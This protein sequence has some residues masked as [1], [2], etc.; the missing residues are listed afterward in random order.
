MSKDVA[1]G[2]GLALAVYLGLKGINVLPVIFLA[3]VVYLLSQAVGLKGLHRRYMPVGGGPGISTVTF[4][5]I[6]GQGTAKKELLEALEFIT[7]REVLKKLGIRPLKGLLLTGPPGTGKTMLAKAAANYTNSVFLAAAGSEFIE[8]YAGVGA[9]RVRQLFTQAREA[10]RRE[11]KKSAV[12]F[13]DEIEV[14]GGQRGKHSSHLEYDQTLNQLLVEMDGISMDDEVNVL[15]V[16]ATNRMDLLDSAL[17]RP[18]RFD[19]LVKVELPD[20]EGRL[21]ILQLHTRNKPL[22][23]DVD[24]EQIARETFGFSGAHLE[25]LTNEAA[26]LAMR[27]EREQIEQRHLLEAIDKVIMGEKLERRPTREEMQRIALHEAAHALVGEINRPGSISSITVTSRGNALGYV[28]QGPRDDRY[29]YTQEYLEA[30]I[31]VLLAGAVAEEEILG[32]R[33]TGAASDFDRAVHHVREIIHSGM[34]YLGVVGRDMLPRGALHRATTKI[35]REQEE[36]VR[37]VVRANRHFLSIV[38]EML[39]ERESLPGDEFRRLRHGITQ[40]GLPA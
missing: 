6:G 28:R 24:L 3:A 22:G 9:Q 13:I 14:L 35:L 7:N 16:G 27:E 26:I 21:Q 34:S 12:I 38:A 39:V 20:K 17:L 2:A 18:G 29:L 4:Q 40:P 25:S 19:R 30:E 32:S 1:I 33:S 5:D 36:K 37:E 8:V 11:G 15:V 31:R 10:A 23:D